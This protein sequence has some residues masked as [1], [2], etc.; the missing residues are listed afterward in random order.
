MLRRCFSTWQLW[1]RLD[2]GQRELLAQQE[3]TRSKMAALIS[4]TSTGKLRG[5][6]APAIDLGPPG[7][8]REGAHREGDQDRMGTVRQVR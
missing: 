6:E 7:P 4:H 2:K 3:E 8:T 5:P 1:W